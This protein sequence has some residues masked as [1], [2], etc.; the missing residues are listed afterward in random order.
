MEIHW[1][2]KYC[3]IC[4]RAEVLTLEHVIPNSLGGALTCRFL[5][6][7]CN[8]HIGHAHEGRAK[9]DPTV[10]LL[11]QELQ[12]HLPQLA[13]QLEE[14]QNYFAIGPGPRTRGSI[15]NGAFLVHGQKQP[16]GS[17]IQH[18]SIAKATIRKLLS[19]DGLSECEITQAIDRFEAA[20][21]DTRI[22]LTQT[23]EVTKWS[24][25]GL[26]PALEGPLMKPIVAVKSAYEFLALQLGKSIYANS[27]PLRAVRHAVQ[28]GTIPEQHIVVD[29]LHAPE[30]KPIHGLVFEG[31]SPHAKVQVRLFGKLAFRVNFLRLSVGGE[32]LMYTHDLASNQES[33]AALPEA[34]SQPE[35]RP[36]ADSPGSTT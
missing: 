25:D 32:R 9:T 18:T 33:F 26:R 21:D 5:C 19:K 28:S 1:P 23:L 17:L 3:I 10:R 15:K 27:P 22:A 16:D 20:P 11:A 12:P 29:R 7:T 13:S 30:A 14:G 24:I 34:N 31:N 35:V 8:S 2:H 4:L 36:D 6:K